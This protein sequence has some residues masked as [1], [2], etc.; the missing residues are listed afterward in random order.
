[1]RTRDQYWTGQT[2]I[3][4]KHE[5]IFDAYIYIYTLYNTHKYYA[6]EHQRGQ[7]ADDVFPSSVKTSSVFLFFLGST[8]FRRVAL[9]QRT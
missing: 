7:T 6:P 4:G 8:V 3:F 9:I 2:T 1:M 5:K